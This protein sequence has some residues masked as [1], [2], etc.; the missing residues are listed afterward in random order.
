MLRLS[1]HLGIFLA[2]AVT[3][4]SMTPPDARAQQRQEYRSTAPSTVLLRDDLAALKGQEAQVISLQLP[5]GW[6]GGWHYHT[7]D[8]FV[9]VQDGSFTVD[10]DGEGRKTFGRGQVY[11]EAVNKVMRA[12]NGSTTEQTTIIVFQVGAK[13]EPL[14]FQA[15]AP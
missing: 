11:H 9:Y 1:L 6:V 13:G 12:R 3:A 8:V 10:V 14:M 15:E 5:P 2:S 4:G 7:G